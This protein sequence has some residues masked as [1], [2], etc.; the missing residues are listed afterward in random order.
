MNKEMKQKVTLGLAGLIFACA[1][2]LGYLASTGS[3]ANAAGVVV[4]AAIFVLSVA[5]G[6]VNSKS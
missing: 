5:V 3:L 4:M 6:V 1:I 2:G